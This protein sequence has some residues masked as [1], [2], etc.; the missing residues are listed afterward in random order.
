M[1]DLDLPVGY[2]FRTRKDRSAVMHM[3]ENQSTSQQ[4]RSRDVY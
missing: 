4:S 3:Q 1:R 2:G